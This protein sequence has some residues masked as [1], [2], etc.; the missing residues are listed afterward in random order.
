VEKPY[1][2]G[3]TGIAEEENTEDNYRNNDKFNQ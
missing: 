2:R 3:V 1:E